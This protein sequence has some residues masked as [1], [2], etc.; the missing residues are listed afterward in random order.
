MCDL[1]AFH[2][3]PSLVRRMF[4]IVGKTF[5]F[6]RAICGWTLMTFVAGGGIQRHYIFD[7]A[8]AVDKPPAHRTSLWTAATR[9]LT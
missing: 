2:P 4:A 3:N 1:T 5:W 7:G 9:C 8:P 6:V